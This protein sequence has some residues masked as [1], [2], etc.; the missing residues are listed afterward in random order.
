[1]QTHLAVGIGSILVG[2]QI[3]QITR[4]LWLSGIV[5][6]MV[7]G[8]GLM[9]VAIALVVLWM[10][11]CRYLQMQPYSVFGTNQLEQSYPIALGLF[12]IVL[13]FI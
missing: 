9:I 7:L 10:Q 5:P 6:P 11:W 8:L 1:M 12:G 4:W 3:A 13:G 2:G